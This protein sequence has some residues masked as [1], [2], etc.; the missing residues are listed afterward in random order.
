[1]PPVGEPAA[2]SAAS[3]DT[4]REA[5][6]GP[7]WRRHCVRRLLTGDAYIGIAPALNSIGT[8]ACAGIESPRPMARIVGAI[9]SSHTPTIG[10]ALDRAKHSYPVWA[11]IFATHE[12][13]RRWLAADAPDLLLAT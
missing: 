7:A 2:S 1:M 4:N 9:A 6:G 10:F 11:P 12:P 3:A 13:I 8:A 5:P